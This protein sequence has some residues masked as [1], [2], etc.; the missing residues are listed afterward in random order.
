MP[1]RAKEMTA[2]ELKRLKPGV[3]AAGGVAGLYL[4]VSSPLARSWLLRVT[5]GTKRRE[6]GLGAYPE[7]GLAQARLFAA[8]MKAEIRNGI[9]PIER[10]K[11]A[12]AA[13][14][15]QQL[16]GLTFREAV[17]LYLPVKA[18]ELAEGKYRD[19]WRDSLYKYA[20]PTLGEMRVHDIE[21]R[22]I[23]SVLEPHWSTIPVTADK[24]RRKLNEIL[25]FC[26][27]R[28]HRVGPNPARWAGN[29]EHALG[30]N[31]GRSG[32]DHY[33]AVQLKDMLRLWQ[34]LSNREGMGAAALRFQLLCATRVGAVRFMTWR[35]L[36]LENRI[37]TVQPGRVSSKIGRNDVAKRVP[38]TEATLAILRSLPRLEG[39]DLVF[40][41]PRGGALSDAT[42]GKLM[43]V[44]HES[45]VRAGNIGFLDAKTGEVA[46]PHG[47]RTTFKTWAIEQTSYEWQLSEVAIWHKVGSKVET[48]YARSDMLEKRRQMMDDWAR[49]VIGS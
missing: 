23:L 11:E 31:P 19:Q 45:D 37:W 33:P 26:T 14:E 12:R 17:D 47:F 27:V 15:A 20:I 10:R 8:E 41:A 43:K 29:L 21:L 5:I 18:R 6:I 49:F 34:A 44:M 35:E 28:G 36:D 9:D 25:D 4:Q 39:N 30:S 1:R 46:V 13:L 24:L 3:H 40:W 48:A 7:V 42:L 38:L 2:I 32:E 22:H 16:R